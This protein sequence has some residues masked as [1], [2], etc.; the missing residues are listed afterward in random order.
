M[1]EEETNCETVK[2]LIRCAMQ[3][4][5]DT[6]ITCPI[7]WT[8]RQLKEKLADVC[9]SKPVFYISFTG[10][11]LLI[12]RRSE[13]TLKIFIA[14]GIDSVWCSDGHLIWGKANKHACIQTKE[15]AR[16]VYPEQSSEA[17]G[18]QVEVAHLLIYWQ[19]LCTICP[20]VL[21]IC[22]WSAEIYPQGCYYF[23]SVSFLKAYLA[24]LGHI[25]LIFDQALPRG[26]EG[27]RRIVVPLY[28]QVRLKDV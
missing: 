27:V 2:L 16:N 7:D 17:F 4:F 13:Q 9:S 6:P 1:G 18:A 21:S 26:G 5:E 23:C 12:I 11:L 10:F 8:V 24:S 25:V 28:K 19:Y 22:L 3:S 20:N 14:C 15:T